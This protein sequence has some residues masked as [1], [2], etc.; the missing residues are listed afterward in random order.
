MRKLYTVGSMLLLIFLLAANFSIAQTVRLEQGQNGGI[1]QTP[2]S[3]VNWATG[4]SNNSNSHFFESQSIPYRLTISK[5]RADFKGVIEIEWDTRTNGKSAID[6]ITG[7]DRICEVVEPVPGLP[8]GSNA[9]Q[10]ATI[11]APGAGSGMP[12]ASFNQIP[13]SDRM[14]AIHGGQLGTISY[15]VQQSPTSTSAITRLRINFTANGTLSG[16]N[17]SVVI[18]WG[19]H[20]A[21]AEDWGEGNSASSIDGSPYHTRVVSLN[22]KSIGSQDRSV[23]AASTSIDLDPD[24]EIVG[25]DKVCAGALATYSIAGGA[26]N[27]LWLVS[28]GEITSGQGTNS[29]SVNWTTSGTV[30]VDVSNQGSCSPTSCSLDVKLAQP[31]VISIKDATVCSSEEGGS[32]SIVNLNDYASTSSGTLVFKK[33]IDGGTAEA[34]A[35]PANYAATRG[36]EIEVSIAPGSAC[37]TDTK[38]FSIGIT[39]KQVFG[40]CAPFAGKVYELIG[41]EL[42]MLYD[43][44]DPTKPLKTNEVFYIDGDL[45]LV[46]VIF[47]DKAFF[48]SL[49]ELLE[50][51]YDFEFTEDQIE[52]K[53]FEDDF[54][55]AG[56][57]PIANLERLNQEILYIQYV[58]PAFPPITNVGITTT[59]GDK[60]MRSDLVKIGYTHS[61]GDQ[62]IN[63]T[64]IKVGVLSDSYATRTDGGVNPLPLDIA[65]GDLPA[66]L[67]FFKELPSRYGRGTDEGRAMLQ[68]IH[69]VAPGAELGFRT[70]VVTAGDFAQGILDLAEAK[71]NVIVDDI[72]YITEPFF[73]DG[74]VA[75]AV[76]EVT[77]KGVSY[78][79][80]AGNFGSKSFEGTFNPVT[81]EFI[82]LPLNDGEWERGRVHEFSSGNTTQSMN[83]FPSQ[84]GPAV[85]MVVLQWD[86]PLY[87][88]NS[89][90]SLYDLDIYLKDYKGVPLFG[91]NRNNT[92][93]DP[94]EVLSF[95]VSEATTLELVIARECEACSDIDSNKGIKFK[96][97]VFRGELDPNDPNRIEASTIVG[98]ANAEGAMTVGA[99]LYSNTSAFG[100]NPVPPGT[101]PFTVA[102]FSSRGGTTT[103]NEKRN[104]P[105][106]TAPNGVN[107]TVDLGAPDFEGDKIPN[108][109]G[110]S[111]AAPHAAAVAALIQQARLKYYPNTTPNDWESPKEVNLPKDIRKLMKNSAEDMHESGFDFKSGTG[112]VRA[113]RALLTLA[114]PNPDNIV[115]VYD[116]GID[117][118]KVEFKLVISGTNLIEDSEVYIRGEKI[119]SEYNEETGNLEVNML[120]LDG[121][122]PITVVNPPK[123]E[124]GTDG[125]TAGPVFFFNVKKRT[126]AIKLDNIRKKF[127][128]LVKPL[129]F[130]LIELN[131]NNEWVPSVLTL[132]EIG[133]TTDPEDQ[134][135]DLTLLTISS[136]ITQFGG[137]LAKSGTYIIRASHPGTGFQ[138]S[139]FFIYGGV[140]TDGIVNYTNGIFTV[141]QLPITIQPK[142]LNLE[143]GKSISEALEFE[144]IISQDLIESGGE[145]KIEDVQAIKSIILT[146]YL[147]DLSLAKQP[148]DTSLPLGI[149]NGSI[150]LD[151]IK[152]INKSFMVSSQTMLFARTITNSRPIVNSKPIINS[153]FDV[154]AESF[155]DYL[156]NPDNQVL[157][158]VSINSR[159][160]INI[161][162]MVNSKTIVNSRPIV[163]GRIIINARPIINGETIINTRTI[164]NSSGGEGENEDGNS[165]VILGEKDLDLAEE[166][167]IAGI[168]YYDFGAE[169]G[170]NDDDFNLE[171]F[172]IIMVTGTDVGQHF[173]IPGTFESR[174]FN[175]SYLPADLTITPSKLTAT[176]TA[177]PDRI[178][179]R[180]EAPEFTTEFEGF[181]YST[182][183]LDNQ[184]IPV[185]L[186]E[187]KESV[188]DKIEYKLRKD[189]LDYPSTG[190][191][192]IGNYSIR[193]EVKLFTPANYVVDLDN[194]TF[195]SLTVTGC[196]NEAPEI[197]T[198]E[199]AKGAG[200]TSNPATIKR[201][202]HTQVGDLL[203][204]GLMF[205]KGQAPS[206]TPQDKGWVEIQR[207]NQL[208]QVAMITYYKVVSTDEPDTYGF[209]ISQSPKWTMGISRVSGADINHPDGPIASFSG[210]SGAQGFVATA[211]S[212]ITID[213]NTM[214][215]LFYTNKKNAT[216]TPPT[217]TIEVYD[218][219][220]DQQGL[221]SNMMSYFIQR[222]PG[223][224]GDLSAT[225]SLSEH[226]VA[227]AIAIRPLASNLN[228]A[229]IRALSGEPMT[230]MSI[231]EESS[232]R[233]IEEVSGEIKVYPNPV[234]DRLS[235]SLRGLVEEEPTESSLIIL[236]AMGRSLALPRTWHQSDSRMELDFSQMHVGLYIINI[237]TNQGVKSIRVIKHNP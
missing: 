216:W 177:N 54:I 224:T 100:F 98:H 223:E 7:F 1:N 208:N 106:F 61:E 237:R 127:G 176:T 13:E 33:V 217:G 178:E 220:N 145:V 5:I 109:F 64:G 65:N 230:E 222:E 171:F 160:M 199:T 38:T 2:V 107:T 207:V 153:A 150:F 72:T 117:P 205:E 12:A 125:G 184:E 144:V 143:Y 15:V 9:Y 182:N 77:A 105:D 158:S 74:R 215:M 159:P 37:S 49:V 219:P 108:F 231:S 86:D 226:W 187:N 136:T 16:P 236:D 93:G 122:P 85:Y 191:I 161:R 91:F 32:T 149:F 165:L 201:P 151:R 132:E 26:D 43:L 115:L 45:V 75:K 183:F 163:N 35:D 88:I 131:D 228:S 135:S 214:V 101:L 78:F 69:D 112:L 181:A 119:D 152:F 137:N 180:D 52:I 19:G 232:S 39:E 198:F 120:P 170:E 83:V 62:A 48:T 63:G 146:Q 190:T 189:G 129:T 53:E 50:S 162:T 186:E 227:Q 80:S 55:I 96:Y 25:D 166:V 89:Q 6:Y 164:V 233:Q 67:F 34:I 174:N 59:Q 123:S 56:F 29:I 95:T 157:K 154:P 218:D 10:Y 128:Q 21:S 139:D 206:V 8:F 92:N 82:A 126:V 204:V 11:P 36:D 194:S 90:G 130:N 66:E 76:N 196:V 175:V 200:N 168:K 212:L 58:R 121:N 193:P 210:L 155:V 4:N 20:I 185:L 110:T 103:E 116:A 167:E 79:T 70:G 3:P 134:N 40:V 47:K 42:T 203:I 71:S 31:A 57:I 27:Y 118:T 41:S 94:I 156:D 17:N 22:G 44:F 209:K 99:V 229:R 104:K 73:K 213:C 60:V 142:D 179:F 97:V 211:P 18:A 148:G 235:L 169:I 173:I 84:S 188:V 114:N 124:L 234:K 46:E 133:L 14:L 140:L 81:D 141:E 28:G 195:G 51:E 192:A 221:T 172:S 202:A 23:Q 68:I 225:A 102:T 111:A 30:S 197:Q 147:Q 24:C 113:D 138:F 87:S